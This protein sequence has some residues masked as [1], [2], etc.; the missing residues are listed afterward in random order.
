MC[1][2]QNFLAHKNLI[3][4]TL[5]LPNLERERYELRS[6]RLTTSYIMDGWTTKISVE[7]VSR[8]RIEHDETF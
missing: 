3:Q 2:P 8:L 6:D 5:F 4:P 1:L 7:F